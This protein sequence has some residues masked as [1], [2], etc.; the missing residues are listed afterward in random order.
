MTEPDPS[1]V[2]DA[3]FRYRYEEEV[4][5]PPPIQELAK[6]PTFTPF[7]EAPSIRNRQEVLPEET[8]LALLQALGDYEAAKSFIAK[9]KVIPPQLTRALEM[10]DDVPVDILPVFAAE[11]HLP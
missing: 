10:L 9:Y 5:P 1:V 7:T 11:K 3:L 8:D 4:P 2:R 6:E